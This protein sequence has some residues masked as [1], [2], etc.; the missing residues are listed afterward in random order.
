MSAIADGTGAVSHIGSYELLEEIGRGG[1]G[2]IYKAR[3]THTGRLVAMKVLQ[4]HIVQKPEQLAR[5]RREA[6]AAACLDHPHVLPIYAANEE[7]DGIPFFTMKLATGGSLAERRAELRHQPREAVVLVAK[8]AHAAAHAHERGVLH[9]DLK[10]G[11]ILFDAEDTPMVSDFGL[12]AWLHQDTDLT[13]TEM[14]FGTP[15]YLPPEYLDGRPDTL[16][17]TA[18]VYSLGVILFE[19]LTGRLP[20]PGDTSLESLRLAASKRAPLLRTLAP[21]LDRDLETICARCLESDPV[22]RY[23]SAAALAEDL[24]RWLGGR[25]ILARR[26]PLLVCGWKTVRRHPALS[27]IAALCI[28]LAGVGVALEMVRRT[29]QGELSKATLFDRSIAIVPTEDLDE[30]SPETAAAREVANT[31][32]D[33]GKRESEWNTILLQSA[34]NPLPGQQEMAKLG[35]RVGSRYLL[36]STVRRAESGRRIAMRMIDTTRD[37][38]L[39]CEI[40]ETPVSTPEAIR[41]RLSA[42]VAAAWRERHGEGSGEALP[43]LPRAVEDYLLAGDRQADRR[44]IESYDYAIAAYR[45]AVAESGESPRCLASLGNA[46]AGR[47]FF[48]DRKK[49]LDEAMPVAQKAVLCGPLIARS[50]RTLAMVSYFRGEYRKALE[51][52]LD[53]VELNPDEAQGTAATANALEALG[54]VDE[55]I[56]WYR[57]AAMRPSAPGAYA[58]QIGDSFAILGEFS[59]ARK[60]YLTDVEFRPGLSDGALGL[61]LLALLEG[62]RENALKLIRE[63]DGKFPNDNIV[64]QTRAAFEFHVGDPAMAETLYKNFPPDEDA[65]LSAYLGVRACSALGALALRRGDGGGEVLIK[66]A[67]QLDNE[68]LETPEPEPSLLIEK[69]SNLAL[70]GRVEEAFKTLRLCLENLDWTRYQIEVDPRLVS[71]K[72]LPEFEEIRRGLKEKSASVLSKLE[73]KNLKQKGE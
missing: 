6:R 7:A 63:L 58:S 17:P 2:V 33:L 11:N 21:S 3:D 42:L 72:N 13:T 56:L 31:L 61:A 46:L 38:I 62:H 23:Q 16:L 54:R 41:P 59:E 8:V 48:G 73:S 50:H 18:D 49:W 37:R 36:T 10:P 30:L 39:G 19:L 51:Q 71:L 67:L 22:L 12:A 65:G 27:T 68:R 60:A 25:P 34:P 24:E 64:S 66:R 47:S 14:V 40:L 26:T 5:F 9:R 52:S 29:T 1:M 57:R 4:H 32:L 69:A 45:K 35:Q 43:R 44:T 53:A 28:V 70:L 55:A 15:G 20:F